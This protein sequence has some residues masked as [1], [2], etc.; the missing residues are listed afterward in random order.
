MGVIRRE[1][2]WRLEKREEGL[3]EVTYQREPQVEVRTPEYNPGLIDTPAVGMVDVRKVNSYAEAEGLFE[4][5]AHSG[6]PSGFV[7]FDT[8]VESSRESGS[9]PD[10]DF[11]IADSDVGGGGSFGDSGRT[12]SPGGGELDIDA[13]PGIIGFALILTGG[14]FL[15]TQG[16][17]PD[18]LV[19]QLGTVFSVIGLGVFAWGAYIYRTRGLSEAWSIL[20]SES[21]GGKS[22]G[23]GGTNA[24]T[25]PTPQ[26]LKNEIIFDR[27]EHHCEWCGERFDGLQV[28]H[29]KPRSE[30]GPNTKRN[31]IAL[32]PNCHDKA[33]RGA[34]SRSQL[35]GKVRRIMAE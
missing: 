6:P 18:S 27:A 4:E 20:F 29:I 16:L 8:G 15:Y 5:Y 21:K 17:N 10:G 28:H 32:C 13:P 26:K 7:S 34:I 24:M 12:P 30:G 25:P 2:D 1:G 14:L 19:F 11:G 35:R 9:M 3:Y 23:S 33:D 31:L 22:T